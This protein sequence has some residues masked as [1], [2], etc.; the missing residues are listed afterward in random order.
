MNKHT[1]DPWCVI[2]PEERGKTFGDE[3]TN[4]SGLTV[5]TD[6]YYDDPCIIAEVPEWV[7]GE[8]NSDANLIAAAPDLLEALEEI[9][10][11]VDFGNDQGRYDISEESLLMASVALAKAKGEV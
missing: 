10:S 5:I 3:D 4:Y 9:I 8:G 7:P 6:S 1:K 11:Q 2:T